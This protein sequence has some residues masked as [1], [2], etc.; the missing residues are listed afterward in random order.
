MEQKN[1]ISVIILTHNRLEAVK[2][3]FE[4]LKKILKRKDIFEFIILDNASKDGTAEFVKEFS[5][6]SPKIKVVFSPKNL[7]CAGGRNTLIK[8][9]KGNIILIL[10]SD[11][12]ITS[13][14]FI[15][16]M[17]EKLEQP[18]VG[19][20]GLQGNYLD[21]ST[22][23][24][25][26]LPENFEGYADF[27]SGF[28]QMFKSEVL[29]KG[30]EIDTFYNPYY[31]EDVDFC[32][33]IKK[34]L[35]LNVYAI[36]KQGSGVIH[37][38]GQT[39]LGSDKENIGKLKYLFDKF[40][41][42][43]LASSDKDSIPKIIHQTWKTNKI[44]YS[45]Y[46][47]KWA[48]SWKKYNPDW[49]YKLWTDEE[50]RNLIAQIFPWFLETYDNYPTSIQRA[51][52]IRYFLLYYY[53]GVYVDLDFECLKS[54]T[55]LLKNKSLIFGRVDLLSDFQNQTPNA[56][57]AS[58][59]NNKFW[60]KIF[61]ELIKSKNCAM[62]ENSTGPGMLNKIIS[63][64]EKK[65]GADIISPELV[66][67]LSWDKE[68]VHS[69]SIPQET[70]DNPQKKYP[71]AYAITYWTHNWKQIGE[72]EEKETSDI[73]CQLNFLLDRLEKKFSAKPIKFKPLA[74]KT[75]LRKKNGKGG[76]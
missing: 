1:K 65:Y 73:N 11:I 54:I 47:K 44:P 38:W 20:V 28:C 64:N 3:C 5:K 30:C 14:K 18:E 4:S 10:D 17:L 8:I 39:N 75:F 61:I 55:P 69:N 68:A 41:L 13:E 52:A 25:E 16:T 9:A 32:Y 50:N 37:N 29:E 22:M 2:K 33:Q 59:K 19:I 35:N 43:H 76:N 46:K 31:A 21:P 49:E 26:E 6:T 70:L 40:Q 45:I 53:G 57:M 7:G 24:F 51:D 58:T 67:P 42:N 12:E 27:I 56:F 63:G 23:V 34:N 71:N 72:K 48:E 15:D 62:V 66:Y 36:S 74:V 60:E